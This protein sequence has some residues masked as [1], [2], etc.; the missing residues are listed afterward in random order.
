VKSPNFTV[1]CQQIPSDEASSRWS[2]G[3]SHCWWTNDHTWLHEFS[4]R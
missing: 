2:P 4:T 1:Y 3:T